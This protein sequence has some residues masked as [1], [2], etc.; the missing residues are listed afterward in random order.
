MDLSRK[1]DMEL[2]EQWMR[3]EQLKTRSSIAIV[4]STAATMQEEIDVE[5]QRRINEKAVSK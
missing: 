2:A 3:Y 5:H 4:R 1:S